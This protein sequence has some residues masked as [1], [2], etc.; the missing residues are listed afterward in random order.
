[1][2]CVLIESPPLVEVIEMVVESLL[3]VVPGYRVVTG[4]AVEI[5][6][7]VW[8]CPVGLNMKV[9]G[10]LFCVSHLQMLG[11][12]QGFGKGVCR[13]EIFGEILRNVLFF[14]IFFFCARFCLC[15]RLVGSVQRCFPFLLKY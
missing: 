14:F 11:L 12:F 7:V 15:S 13:G 1:M 10:M 9:L 4:D 5:N 6:P 8:F 2:S 3:V